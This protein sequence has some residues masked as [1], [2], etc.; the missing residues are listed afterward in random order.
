MGTIS[1]T[2]DGEFCFVIFVPSF[3]SNQFLVLQLTSTVP[4]DTRPEYHRVLV[5][6]TAKGL[7]AVSTGGQRSSRTVS[8]AGANGL[9]ELPA[10]TE[11]DKEK[12]K[13]DI[14]QCVMIGDMASR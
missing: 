6:P 8:L 9:L 11:G 5:R 13:G 7:E 12:Q 1:S 4:L 2:S 14:V 3:K 10:S